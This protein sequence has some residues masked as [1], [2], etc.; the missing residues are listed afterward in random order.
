[1]AT[2]ELEM[3]EQDKNCPRSGQDGFADCPCQRQGQASLRG[4]CTKPTNHE[5]SNVSPPT[6]TTNDVKDGEK[7]EIKKAQS[8]QRLL[9]KCTV[10]IPKYFLVVWNI[11]VL[12]LALMRVLILANGLSKFNT[13]I[14][15][16]DL[17]ISMSFLI[18]FIINFI[19]IIW[20][21]TKMK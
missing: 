17:I 9:W 4:D 5:N 7:K 18:T 6:N 15:K 3:S 2:I 12:G 16:Y 20:N 21:I 1:M 8:I 14:Y 10:A 13:F 11:L 19:Y